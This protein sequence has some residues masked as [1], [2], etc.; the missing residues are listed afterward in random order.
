MVD[1]KEREHEL[2]F[3]RFAVFGSVKDITALVVFDAI[4]WKAQINSF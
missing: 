2:L 4:F 1:L 3:F